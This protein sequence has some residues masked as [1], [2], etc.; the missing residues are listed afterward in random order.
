LNTSEDDHEARFGLVEC[1][2]LQAKFAE[3]KELINLGATRA[4]S[5]DLIRAYARKLT[6][7]LIGWADAKENDPR[8]TME[9]RLELL[10][11]ALRLDPDNP[12]LFNRLLKLTKDKSP[13]AQKAREILQ[14][15]AITEKGSYL[16]HL[17]LGIDAWQQDNTAEARMHWE[18]ALELSK[19]AP[20][21]ANNLAWLLAFKPPVD[22]PRAYELINAALTKVPNEPRFRGT[23]GHI[24]FKM[25]RYKE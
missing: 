3:S 8:S 24:L 20:L 19:E 5:P 7:V 13:Q 14:L 22:L 9:E 10:E 1:L 6:T 23:R 21:V 12:E 2:L 17:F 11:T 18:K 15:Y 16:A 4:N 25:E